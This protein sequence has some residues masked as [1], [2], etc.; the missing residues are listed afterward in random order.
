MLVVLVPGEVVLYDVTDPAAP[1]LLGRHPGS[2]FRQVEPLPDGQVL[3]WS[4]RLAAPPLRWD[5][6]TA[7]PGEGFQTV[8]EG[9]P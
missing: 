6:A 8:I 2:A 9:L 7:V 3:L 5:P 1:A 4:P